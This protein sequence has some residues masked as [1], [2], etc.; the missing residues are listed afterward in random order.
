M[1]PALGRLRLLRTW[2]GRALITDGNPI[3]GELPGVA[4]FYNAVPAS[5]GYTTGPICARLLAELLLGRG[6]SRNLRDFSIE[7]F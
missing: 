2:A 6:S 3:L 4:G 1:V 7:R 5:S